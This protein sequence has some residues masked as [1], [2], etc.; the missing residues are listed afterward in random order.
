MTLF[1]DRSNLPRSK[2]APRRHREVSKLPKRG[3]WRL[4]QFATQPKPTTRSN[5][6]GLALTLTAV[7][8]LSGYAYMNQSDTYSNR[9]LTG[10]R[11]DEEL[12]LLIPECTRRLIDTI[13]LD[14]VTVKRTCTPGGG[15]PTEVYKVLADRKNEDGSGTTQLQVP[16][17]D[18][19][20]SED[21]RLHKVLVNESVIP[22]IANATRE[23]FVKIFVQ[24]YR[25][26]NDIKVDAQYTLID[27][28]RAIVFLIAILN[29][30]LL[31][32][33]GGVLAPL[34]GGISVDTGTAGKRCDLATNKELC[35]LIADHGVWHDLTVMINL[36]KHQLTATNVLTK[37][38]SKYT[39]HNDLVGCSIHARPLA[40]CSTLS[41]FLLEIEKFLPEGNERKLMK[42][43]LL[44]EVS[45]L[46]QV[47]VPTLQANVDILSGDLST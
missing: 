5:S 44:E 45:R 36:M 9:R 27:E 18:L 31:N 34:L 15:E 8:L 23:Y 10:N 16:T 6:L 26:A 20:S 21:Q 22:A 3:I 12:K 1:K 7:A 4:K 24:T 47:S 30:T 35:R 32:K 19:R 37:N 41:S 42:E 33:K 17:A 11:R 25:N 46:T 38:G 29:R 2:T 40:I 14:I 43:H 39:L 13:C 28:D